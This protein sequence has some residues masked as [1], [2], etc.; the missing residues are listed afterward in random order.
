MKISNS[1]VSVH[2]LNRDFAK[3]V[4]CWWVKT[5][6][7]GSHRGL[8]RDGKV[9]RPVMIPLK[10]RAESNTIQ[11]PSSSKSNTLAERFKV[12]VL[13]KL[14]TLNNAVVMPPIPWHGLPVET[15][16]QSGASGYSCPAAVGAW[17][18]PIPEMEKDKPQQNKYWGTSCDNNYKNS[19]NNYATETNKR[20]KCNG[21]LKYYT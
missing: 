17:G 3:S 6:V 11:N 2:F 9:L 10:K 16:R 19:K 1:R 21:Q 20:N 18:P 5:D 7:T 8:L 13:Y 15:L 14:L 4:R 12:G